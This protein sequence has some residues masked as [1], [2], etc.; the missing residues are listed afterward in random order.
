MSQVGA[1]VHLPASR[2]ASND[3]FVSQK[4]HCVRHSQC[5]LASRQIRRSDA[6]TQSGGG[7]IVST[8]SEQ[9][10]RPIFPRV[11]IQSFTEIGPGEGYS[12]GWVRKERVKQGQVSLE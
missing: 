9:T 2:H 8:S 5:H 6:L 4:P 7:G 10:S 11:P 3:Q 12:E 1:G